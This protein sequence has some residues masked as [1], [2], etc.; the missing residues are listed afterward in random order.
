MN[1][2]DLR[3][4]AN[5]ISELTNPF[6][7]DCIIRLS[8][9]CAKNGWSGWRYTGTIEFENGNTKGEQKFSAENF[10]AL[11]KKMELFVEELKAE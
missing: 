11:L 5:R 3:E 9:W 10:G 1:S 8:T 7:A 2:I 4:Q 6:E